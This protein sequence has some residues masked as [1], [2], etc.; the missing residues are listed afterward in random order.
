MQG[1][2]LERKRCCSEADNNEFED[3][4]RASKLFLFQLA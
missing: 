4:V 3:M 2:V 1:G